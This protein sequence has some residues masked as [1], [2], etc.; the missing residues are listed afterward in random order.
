[1][2][3]LAFTG[4][5]WFLLFQFGRRGKV[6]PLFKEYGAFFRTHRLLRQY[7]YAG[8][9][10][11]SLLTA[12]T[13]LAMD[14]HTRVLWNV[15]ANRVRQGLGSDT[16]DSFGDRTPHSFNY[17]SYRFQSTWHDSANRQAADLLEAQA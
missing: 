15:H 11:Y 3:G 10:P 5:C 7:L 14:T 8:V 6:L 4:A 13:Y 12:H 2:H 16:R 17:A 1:M 9:L